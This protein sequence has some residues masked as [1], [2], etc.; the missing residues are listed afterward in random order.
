MKMATLRSFANGNHAAHSATVWYH[1]DLGKFC[2][3]QELLSRQSL[4]RLSEL[5]GKQHVQIA[6]FVV[7][8]VLLGIY[9]LLQE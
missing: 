8:M 3:K 9:I 2:G 1:S 6:Y 7:P 5:V 4:Q